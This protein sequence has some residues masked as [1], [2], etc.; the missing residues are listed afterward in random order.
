MNTTPNSRTPIRTCSNLAG[1]SRRDTLGDTEEE[2]TDAALAGLKAEIKAAGA[3][4]VSCIL[5]E[6]VVGANGFIQ[7]PK[8]YMHGVRKI[9]DTY[10][11]YFICDEVMM[12]FGRTGKWF[13]VDNYP[14]I[15]D[16]ITS[17]KGLTAGILP[18]SM[19]AMNDDIHRKL[20]TI[21]TGW[22]TTYQAHP[23]TCAAA[24]AVIEYLEDNDIVGRVARMA[25]IFR[26]HVFRLAAKHEEVV[27]NPR[28]LGFGAGLDLRAQPGETP[29]VETGPYR[30]SPFVWSPKI[31]ELRLAMLK[32]GVYT[33]VLGP[34]CNFAP[35]L[36][37]TED[38]MAWGFERIDK[39]MQ[40]LYK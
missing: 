40:C 11:I 27:M 39:A 19:V 5:M 12:G 25:P 2:V 31:G 23:V 17:A 29:V 20:R 7:Y 6:S 32:E 13:G 15:P 28:S 9:C 26:D 38:E 34:H 4:D 8:G 24:I 37:I 21:A 10:G 1:G 22:G 30:G 35:P 18:L 16:M 36:I 14:V 33:H 3:D